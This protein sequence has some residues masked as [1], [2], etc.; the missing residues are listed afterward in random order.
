[1]K[2]N[3]KKQIATNIGNTVEPVIG[4]VFGLIF[5]FLFNYFYDD[6]AFLS[7]E[8]DQVRS[9]YNTSLVVGIVLHF[10]RL[11]VHSKA[12]K[13]V[14]QLIVNGFFLVI[15]YQ[16]WVLFPFDTS[17]LGDQKTWDFIFRLLII[18]PSIAVGIAIV[19]ELLKLTTG[20]YEKEAN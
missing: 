4:I 20:S 9:L 2:N 13:A 19:V 18:L 1:M 5:L 14:T 3:T 15:A 7:D 10:S 17:V 6:L 12:Y 11:F 8:F 16:F